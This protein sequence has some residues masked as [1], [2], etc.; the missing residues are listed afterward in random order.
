MYLLWDPDFPA[1]FPLVLAACHREKLLPSESE[2]CQLSRPWYFHQV[3]TALS[4]LREAFQSIFPTSEEASPM[5]PSLIL[6][7]LQKGLLSFCMVFA[8]TFL[9][10]KKKQEMTFLIYLENNLELY[11]NLPEQ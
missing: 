10:R 2:K 1:C 11:W 8:N 5:G 3:S 4:S 9:K 7:P 6:C